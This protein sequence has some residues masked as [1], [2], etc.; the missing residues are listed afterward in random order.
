MAAAVVL[1]SVVSH[2]QPELLRAL[3]SDLDR[4]ELPITCKF[5]VTENTRNRDAIDIARGSRLFARGCL[6]VIANED[7]LGFGANHNQAFRRAGALFADFQ[8][9]VFVVLNPD[10]R[11]NSDVISVL[12]S[13]LLSNSKIGVLAP[14][15]FTPDGV[16]DDSARY[17]PTFARLLAK[18]LF[19][20]RGQFPRNPHL[21]YN[22]DWMAGMFLAFN[23]ACFV[24]LGGFDERYF[25]YYEDADICLRAKALGYEV[26]V[27]PAC[28]VVHDA[29]RES[30]R[31][32]KRFAMHLMSMCRFLITQLFRTS[33]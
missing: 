23:A 29:Q 14:E 3:L 26:V 28:Q 2:G 20:E 22:P 31:D 11:L 1:C 15:V 33:K 27:E 6:N 19:N 24:R 5:I 7:M 25:L 16:I 9:Q 12:A 4:L 8:A 10:L 13:A 32:L 21:A 18:L 30:H 17:T